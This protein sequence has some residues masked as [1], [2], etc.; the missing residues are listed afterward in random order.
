M[1]GGN[2]RAA[3]AFVLGMEYLKVRLLPREY[4]TSQVVKYSDIV[5]NLES[6]IL[7]ESLINEDFVNWDY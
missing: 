4:L 3:I 7:F 6:K 5:D 2:H 1:L